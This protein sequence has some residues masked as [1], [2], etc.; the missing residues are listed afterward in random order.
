[1]ARKREQD[2]SS[3]NSNSKA[4]Q[5]KEK[6]RQIQRLNNIENFTTFNNQLT[7]IGL[8]LREIQGDGNCLFR[9]LGDQLEGHGR[10]HLKHR[11]DTVEYM[12][13]HRLDFEPFVEDDIPFD[14]HVGNL[15]TPGSYAGND[16]IVAF[17]KLHSVT[18][19]IHQLGAPLWQINDVN[20]SS[21][22]IVTELHIAY[23]NGDHYNSVRKLGDDSETPAGI[24]LNISKNKDK[25]NCMQSYEDGYQN[26]IQTEISTPDIDEYQY[27]ELVTSV[28]EKT[29]CQDVLLIRDILKNQRFD[30]NGTIDFILDFLAE[31]TLDP[32][33]HP[34]P[35]GLWAPWGT[36]TRL[37]GLTQQDREIQVKATNGDK[38]AKPKSTSLEKL[39]GRQHKEFKRQE[40]KRA[41]E[42]RKRTNLHN[43]DREIEENCE[44]HFQEIAV[45][46][47]GCLS[48]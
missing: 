34:N 10:N 11:E 23:H 24:R 7:A 28:M 29:G 38:G 35:S 43:N 16:A 41:N 48:I 2:K 15:G 32:P 8:T 5:R 12:R 25:V 47:L 21:E 37:F 31:K 4:A 42:E 36:G 20:D 6:E 46:G 19:V 9:A 17:A 26:G 30:L 27:S 18:I 1:M 13:N 22:K 44:N 14:K 45:D 40:R 3:S 33:C 39:S